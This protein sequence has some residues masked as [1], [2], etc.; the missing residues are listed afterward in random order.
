MFSEMFPTSANNL[1]MNVHFCFVSGTATIPVVNKIVIGR[2]ETG[3]S[4]CQPPKKQWQS[5]FFSLLLLLLHKDLKPKCSK[6]FR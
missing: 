5:G 3:D 1:G 2:E 4:A 6:H